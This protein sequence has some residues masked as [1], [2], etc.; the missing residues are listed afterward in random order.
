MKYAFFPGC[1]LEG[2]AKE[3][4]LATTAVTK[5]LDIELI[6]IPGWTC[7]GASHVQDVDDLAATAINARSIALAEQMNLPLLTVCNTCTLMLRSAKTK[8][9]NGQ[10]DQVNAILSSAGLKYQGTSHITHLLWILVND[11]G[12]EKLQSNVTQP[13]FKLKVAPYYGCHILRPPAIMNVEDH[14]NPQTLEKLIRALGAESVD[15][16]AR[17][18]CCG[19]HATYTAAEDI[20]RITG[21]TNQCA[22][23]AGADCIVTP[24][25]LCQ[26]SLDMNQ[27]EGQKAVNCH[28]EMPVLHLAQLVGLAIGL[29]PDQLGL[30]MHIAGREAIKNKVI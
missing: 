26:M 6:E 23:K 4:Y 1:V 8:L 27:P 24:C 22:V 12:L 25:P 20:I 3:N 13:L 21:E 16:P 11:Y 7:C 18:S 17:L 28:M 19:F 9:D 10:K 2:A 29:A 15:F 14:A 5:A 30:N